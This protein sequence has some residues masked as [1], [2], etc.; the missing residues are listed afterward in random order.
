MTKAKDLMVS[1]THSSA[2]VV[3]TW[4]AFI[5][6]LGATSLGICYLPVNGWVRAY[7]G[8]GLA[9]TVGSTISLSKT[10]RDIHEAQ[11]LAARVD[12]AR[13]ER[14]LAEHHPLK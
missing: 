10:T 8:M 1:P 6:S 11:K 3:Q 2:W 4:A 7:F 5:I 13:V 9:F 12:E 14:L